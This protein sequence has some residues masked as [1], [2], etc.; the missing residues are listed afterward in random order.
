MWAMDLSPFPFWSEP[1]SYASG[2]RIAKAVI[3]SRE[4][5]R[6][7]GCRLAISESPQGDM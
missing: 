2:Y 4:E 3:H 5:G 7:G 1:F 6:E